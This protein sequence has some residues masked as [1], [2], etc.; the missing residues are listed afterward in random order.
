MRNKRNRSFFVLLVSF[1][2]SAL[3]FVP[4]YAQNFSG[5]GLKLGRARVRPYITISGNVDDNVLRDNEN[6]DS[7]IIVVYSPGIQFVLP[8]QRHKV[9][10]NYRGDF[11][12]YSDFSS[13]NYSDNQVRAD[14]NIRYP[15]GLN[16]DLVDVY[17]K[18]HDARGAA[19][20]VEL[21][22]FNTNVVT[23]EVG[24]RL[25]EKSNLKIGYS[26]LFLDYKDSRNDFRDRGDNSVGASIFYKIFSKTSVLFEYDFTTVSFDK[27]I[28]TDN[29][30]S[31]IQRIYVG[32]TGDI[33]AMT[34]G[35]IRFGY[36]DKNFDDGTKSDFKGGTV[37][38]DISHKFSPYCLLSLHLE[39][40]TKESNIE[41]QNY[42][43][44]TGVGLNLDHKINSMLEVSLM[45]TF[46]RDKYPEES[47]I[48]G[49]TERREDDTFKLGIVGNYQ[50]QRWINASLGYNYIKRDSVFDTLDYT[51]NL[52]TLNISLSL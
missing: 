43:V 18:G 11:G 51:D 39:R 8:I 26:N 28:G 35:T 45:G 2:L 50:I 9:S 7:D 31:I 32:T 33:T 29:R 30:D 19:Q 22:L 23:F 49:I 17:K 1:L 12:R 52:Y 44:T 20:N 37:S 25:G 34:S 36:E 15:G 10:L 3:F 41:N 46:G 4:V 40:G 47:I 13:E 5:R 48:N 27:K 24:Y 6:E 42:Y 21:D 38:G 16:L 14:M